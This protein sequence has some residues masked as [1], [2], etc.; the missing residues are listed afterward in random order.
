MN[1]TWPWGRLAVQ[2]PHFDNFGHTA[3]CQR[4]RE[5]EWEWVDGCMRVLAAASC[6]LPLCVVS[7][8]LPLHP[9]RADSFRPLLGL[10][11]PVS[12]IPA[13][14]SP[15]GAPK[16]PRC[17]AQP[18]QLRRRIIDWQLFI[19]S[20]F[21]RACLCPAV[22]PCPPCFDGGPGQRPTPIKPS[23]S[24][25]LPSPGK[26]R[27][28]QVPSLLGR[29]ETRVTPCACPVLRCTVRLS[30]CSMG[31][32]CICRCRMHTTH[33]EEQENW[34][35]C[36]TSASYRLNLGAVHTSCRPRS[37]LHDTSPRTRE[38]AT[39]RC[40]VHVPSIAQLASQLAPWD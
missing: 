24:G 40:T 4:T 30:D 32:I 20:P 29:I 11:H 3:A 26:R 1:W 18:A 8:K 17:T 2:K 33:W 38:H 15:R 21:V 22:L 27:R 6:S 12:N 10:D 39:A 37:L 23:R 14:T 34:E 9:R 13:A 7:L 28:D 16:L 35:R 31:T 25:P 5:Y 19:L 36:V